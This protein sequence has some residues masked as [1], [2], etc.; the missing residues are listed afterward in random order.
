M[1]TYMYTCIEV[2][3]FVR[4]Y[5]VRRAYGIHSTYILTYLDAY[6]TYIYVHPHMNRRRAQKQF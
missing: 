2:Q 3:V 1:Y 5:D 4:V 6:R